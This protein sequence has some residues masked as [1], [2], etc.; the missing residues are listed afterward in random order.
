MF[1]TTMFETGYDPLT[2]FILTTAAVVLVVLIQL[3]R[4]R[5][6]ARQSN[7]RKRQ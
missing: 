7:T 4:G 3:W 5:R 2:G 6:A 1:D